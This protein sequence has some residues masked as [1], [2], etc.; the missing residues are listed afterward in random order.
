MRLFFL[1]VSILV[2]S[3]ASKG[4]SLEEKINFC[5]KNFQVVPD[6]TLRLAFE[7][8]KESVEKREDKNIGLSLMYI[9]LSHDYLGSFDSALY[10]FK[11]AEPLIN[12]SNDAK[13]KVF[14]LKS[15]AN[16]Y[17][18][19]SKLEDALKNYLKGLGWPRGIM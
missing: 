6:K 18:S 10:Y 9:G 17:Y 16:T 8:Y 2:F 7:A 12:E 13:T 14:F 4:L 5:E 19:L 3:L 15:K 11:K 1:L